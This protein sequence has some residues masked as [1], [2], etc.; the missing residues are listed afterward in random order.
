VS[1]AAAD[2]FS[3]RLISFFSALPRSIHPLLVLSSSASLVLAGAGATT[4]I[5]DGPSLLAARD[6]NK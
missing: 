1:A 2:F 6:L 5:G 4:A 3:T